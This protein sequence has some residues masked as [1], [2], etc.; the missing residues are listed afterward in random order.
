M[1]FSEC[2]ERYFCIYDVLLYFA[3]YFAKYC[4]WLKCHFECTGDSAS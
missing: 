2:L 3:K 1:E 4:E